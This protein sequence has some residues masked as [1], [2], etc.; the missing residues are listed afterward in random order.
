MPNGVVA[1]SKKQNWRMANQPETKIN[2]IKNTERKGPFPKKNSKR[3]KMDNKY[4]KTSAEGHGEEDVSR[5]ELIS[6][7]TLIS[8]LTEVPL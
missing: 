7:H 5:A 2:R 8:L 3:R 4:P 6:L 1:V